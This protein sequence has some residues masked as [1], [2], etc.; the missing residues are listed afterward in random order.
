MGLRELC[1]LVIFKGDKEK[2]FK[3]DKEKSFPSVHSFID[4]EELPRNT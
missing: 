4:D 2:F 3:G 1:L